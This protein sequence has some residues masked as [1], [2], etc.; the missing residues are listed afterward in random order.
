MSAANKRARSLS[1]SKTNDKSQC[2]FGEVKKVETEELKYGKGLTK[3]R[4]EGINLTLEFLNVTLDGK[5]TNAKNLLIN[6]W[7]FRFN[8]PSF[9]D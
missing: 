9:A 2:D 8:N 4:C 1:K 6:N 3:F 7:P 5:L